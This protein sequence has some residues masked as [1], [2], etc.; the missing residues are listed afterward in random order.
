MQID[1]F[2]K[3]FDV[4]SEDCL[5]LNVFTPEVS[6]VRILITFMKY[7]TDKDKLIDF[8]YFQIPNKINASK[9]VMVFIHGGGFRRAA[10]TKGFFSPDHLMKRD[11]IIVMMNYRL[12]A[13]GICWKISL[14]YSKAITE[15]QNQ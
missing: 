5:H 13:F 3:K 1:P 15:Q 14:I 10:G 7:F 4:G 11:V 8:S 2:I 12:L 6:Y 9:P